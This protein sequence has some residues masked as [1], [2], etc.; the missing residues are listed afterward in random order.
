M[1]Q[2][3]DQIRDL[4]LTAGQFFAQVA[5][6]SLVHI[7][8]LVQLLDFRVGHNL[9]Q[10]RLAHFRCGG[11]RTPKQQVFNDGAI[12]QF[13]ILV[14]V[15]D[16]TPQKVIVNG[17][18]VVT[19]DV[20]GP[21]VALV[22]LDQEF[23]KR[24]LALSGQSGDANDFVTVRVQGHAD[25]FKDH[26]FAVVAV[27]DV[28]EINLLERK[29]RLRL[30]DRQDRL[31][32]VGHVLE[33]VDNVLAVTDK[34]HNVKHFQQ[35][36]RDL[37]AVQQ[38]DGK[39]GDENGQRNLLLRHQ[40]D[41]PK[42]ATGRR[43]QNNRIHNVHVSIHMIVIVKGGL[44]DFRLLIPVILRLLF[45]L[46]AI[47]NLVE[48]VENFHQLR[49]ALDIETLV[50]Q[51]LVH[52]RL[53]LDEIKRRQ[54][55]VSNNKQTTHAEIVIEKVSC[56]DDEEDNVG[57]QVGNDV[58]EKRETR[59]GQLIDQRV[60]VGEIGIAHGLVVDFHNHLD[61][62]K[63][64]PLGQLGHHAIFEPAVAVVHGNVQDGNEDKVA[65]KDEGVLRLFLF[66]MLD[67]VGRDERDAIGLQNVNGNAR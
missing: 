45:R 11:R 56:D 61:N 55:H 22:Q 36:P 14:N 2:T 24:T 60:N 52:D 29:I 42:G 40:V 33:M 39:E 30:L 4:A 9:G 34:V 47:D 17:F 50:V 13:R 16:F 41:Q 15:R 3:A 6:R 26:V 5:T 53:P 10:P 31:V 49:L 32:V 27:R 7:D 43:R 67:N 19:V 58:G 48:V 25:M 51:I 57:D 1:N 37:F 65:E 28:A 8:V 62:L 46:T 12:K 59:H 64:Q 23:H 35:G 18:N 44:G 20:N 63:L 66:Q 54:S 38:K 21:A